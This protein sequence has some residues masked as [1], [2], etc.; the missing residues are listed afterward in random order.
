MTVFLSPQA[1]Q[2]MPPV[3]FQ[4]FAELYVSSGR[5]VL[6]SAP[7]DFDLLLLCRIPPGAIITDCII[8]FDNLWALGVSSIWDTALWRIKSGGSNPP[9]DMIQDAMIHYGLEIPENTT[10][11]GRMPA[12]Q[13][14][15]IKARMARAFYYDTW[16]GCWLAQ[17]GNTFQTNSVVGIDAFFRMAERDEY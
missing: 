12:P 10:Y 6:E 11:R 14:T 3:T 2:T 8:D 5:I 15:Q 4:T 7:V 1:K 17:A 16:V 13:T 9:Y